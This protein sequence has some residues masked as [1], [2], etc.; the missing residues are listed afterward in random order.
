M[1]AQAAEQLIALYDRSVIVQ[2][3]LTLQSTIANYQ[4]AKVPFI[5]ILEAVTTLYADRWARTTLLADHA[6]IRVSIDEAALEQAAEMTNPAAAPAG[7]VR[8]GGSSGM[9]GGM[10]G[11]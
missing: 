9:G 2:D 5:S 7:S 6:R 3:E 11:R 8:R 4:T 10:S 1:R